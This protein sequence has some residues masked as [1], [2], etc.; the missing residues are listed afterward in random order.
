M[1]LAGHA[2]CPDGESACIA[3]VPHFVKFSGVLPELPQQSR[4]GYV[5]VTFSIY[6]GQTG[7][8][9]LWQEVQN[10]QVDAQGRYMAML[11]ASTLQGI[12][13]DTFFGGQARWLGVRV[14]LPGASERP[15]VLLVSVPYALEA[16]NAQTLGGLPPSAFVKTTSNSP[17]ANTADS[18]S[19]TS[20]K[21]GLGVSTIQGPAASQPVTTTGGT[22]NAISK[23]ASPTSIVDSQ[24]TDINGM[25]GMQNLSN[26]LFA[27]QFSGG[28]P[29]AVTACP[30]NGC[31]IYALSPKM[32]LNLGTIDPGSK[33]VTIYLGPYVYN[34]SQVVLR[35][36]LK[37]IGMG[38]SG[39]TASS[40][41]CPASSPCNGTTLQS[42]NGNSPVFVIP[43]M[44]NNP[45][46]NVQLSGFR[47]LGSAG[48]TNEDAFFLDVSS[49]TNAGLW[50][51]T[52]ND[53]QISGFSGIGI[54]L[55]GPSSNFGALNQWLEF[56]KVVVFR[57]SG[58]GNA[59]RIEGGNF[60]L[61]FVDC[62]FDGQGAGDGTNIYIGGLG[63]AS[64]VAGFPLNITFQ[65]L[66][67]QAAATAVQLDGVNAIA[68]YNSHHEKL[69]GV[70]EITDNTLI[71]NKGVTIADAAF[72][73]VGVNN[74]AG[75]LLSVATTVA[76]GIIF[77]DNHIF[78]NPDS[79]VKAT[80]LS[81]VVYQDND[82]SGTFTVPPT[83]GIT[84][85]LNPSPTL[86]VGGAH[87]VW[88]NPAA[89]PVTTIQSS[90]GPGEFLTLFVR[91]GA[92]TFGSGGNIDL[93]G[94]TS[95][96]VSGS[97]TFM[98]T[99]GDGS[100]AWVPISQWPSQSSS[101]GSSVTVSPL[102]L[103]FPNQLVA[104]TSSPQDITLANM[105]TT[106]LQITGI[107][108]S[109]DFGETSTCGSGLAAN[110]SCTINVT[111]TPSVAGLRSGSVTITDSASNSPQ[112]VTLS[113]DGIVGAFNLTG[114]PSSLTTQAG[115][116]AIFTLTL[117]PVGS[118][119]GSIQF[120]CTGQPPTSTCTT[121]PNP[122]ALTGSAS[123]HSTVQVVTLG[124]R[125]SAAAG[126]QPR[127]TLLLAWRGVQLAVLGCFVGIAAGDDRR[128]MERFKRGVT[129]VALNIMLLSALSCG[130]S[131]ATTSRTPAG[132]YAITIRATSGSLSQSTSFNLTV[133]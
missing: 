112:S 89:T 128:R 66:V 20:Q 99:D 74:G 9:P 117:T 3:T 59:L 75:Y 10:V 132:T 60:E 50:Y 4:S 11:G 113:G 18:A 104:T 33:A 52:L 81:Q 91:G 28:V 110:A 16:G 13:Q 71:G 121:L 49:L 24:I 56:N 103:L 40:V 84:T 80:N 115:E 123:V 120:A 119:V 118:F 73:D 133:L 7:G 129:I 25:V 116:T 30:V 90:L 93:L 57:N 29:D 122:L 2:Q 125:A 83:T 1:T 88:L 42:T 34:I 6:S 63:V 38:A 98:R 111:F 72:E 12:P 67:S 108:A 27:D 124:P 37:I 53:V 31:V 69:W 32:N 64:G 43:Q 51:S 5:G 76:S 79:V 126:Q 130:V 114:S 86:N 101:S 55:R 54:H 19:V 22:A 21:A 15:R 35:K 107:G 62:E 82:Y 65:G 106:A 109:G 39:G 48:N 92:V 41:E 85:G 23:F 87:S 105:G 26:I 97:I 95:V 36:S 68:F 102:S 100:L 70:Y 78:G 61:R 58:G 46:T 96:T 17:A 127:S 8:A 14:N 45:A 131:P 77:R 47:L 44:N 94:I